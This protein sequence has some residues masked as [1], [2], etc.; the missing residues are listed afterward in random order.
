VKYNF[1]YIPGAIDDEVQAIKW[2]LENAGRKYANELKGI[3]IATRKL[4]EKNPGLAKPYIEIDGIYMR[5]LPKYPYT[6]FLRKDNLNY[7]IIALAFRHQS[8]DP[9]KLKKLLQQRISS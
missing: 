9:E 1:K 5:T 6:F 2:Y 8:R 4:L 3:I 7:E